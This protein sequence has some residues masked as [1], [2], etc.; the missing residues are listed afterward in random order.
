[1]ATASEDTC[2]ICGKVDGLK[3]CAR[4]K[5]ISY[6]SSAC[7]RQDWTEHK[8]VCSFTVTTLPKSKLDSDALAILRHMPSPPTKLA[9]ATIN[10]SSAGMNVFNTP[11][12]R[13]EVFAMLPARELLIA[14]RVCRSWYLHVALESDLQ[15]RLFFE[16]G[17]GRLIFTADDGRSLLNSTI[18]SHSH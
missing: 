10:A 17:P 13:L 4:C 3:K 16:P 11:E 14:Q 18:A 6:C 7:Q 8:K 12:L 15:Q 2:A 9:K 1:M 5:Q